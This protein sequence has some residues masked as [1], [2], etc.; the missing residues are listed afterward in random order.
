MMAPVIIPA[1]ACANDFWLMKGCLIQKPPPRG[2]A[3]R[4]F[5]S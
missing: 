3:A 5:S 2:I 1:D 4:A